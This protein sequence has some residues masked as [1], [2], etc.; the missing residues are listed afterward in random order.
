MKFLCRLFL[1]F[2][3]ATIRFVQSQKTF[4]ALILYLAYSFSHLSFS[5]IAASFFFFIF[6]APHWLKMHVAKFRVLFIYEIRIHLPLC[7]SVCIN[8]SIKN[9]E[10]LIEELLEFLVAF[11]LSSFRKK[12]HSFFFSF[13]FY[14]F[15]LVVFPSFLIIIII[16]LLCYYKRPKY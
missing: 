1:V 4:K 6:F 11:C 10:Y 15:L 5:K 7:N 9:N 16:V 12:F 13:F 2:V 14:Y 8:K 3:G